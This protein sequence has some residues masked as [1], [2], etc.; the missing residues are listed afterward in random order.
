MFPFGGDQVRYYPGDTWV[1]YKI[2]MGPMAVDDWLRGPFRDL[3]SNLDD[4]LEGY[5]YFFVR[6]MDPDFHIR[7]RIK[8][9]VA[10]DFVKVIAN[11][12]KALLVLQFGDMWKVEISTYTRE[13]ER[14]GKNIDVF[15]RAFGVDSIFWI[16]VCQYIEDYDEFENIRWKLALSS[17]YHYY[18]DLM[19][20]TD[21]WIPILEACIDSLQKEIKP[22]KSFLYQTDQKFRHHQ[23]DLEKYISGERI[24]ALGLGVFFRN[25]SEGIKELFGDMIVEKD[26]FN[27]SKGRQNITDLVHMSLNRGLRS[28]HRVQEFVLYR[29]LLKL[30]RASK[31]R[32]NL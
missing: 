5:S 16:N 21:N 15:E 29:Y 1:Y 13:M 28:K 2:Y 10:K 3:L 20:S 19:G 27:T 14:Y 4:S 32:G 26:F 23:D 8:L 24:A 11:M 25:R 7:L 12:Y 17:M 18:N 31:A 9:P 6:Y 30:V 22:T